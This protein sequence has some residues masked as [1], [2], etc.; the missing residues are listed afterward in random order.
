MLSV[1]RRRKNM[2]IGTLTYTLRNCCV[3]YLR[4]KEY[5]IM[6]KVLRICKI[7]TLRDYLLFNASECVL[8]VKPQTDPDGNTR[9]EAREQSIKT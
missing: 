2:D 9:A 8:N 5:E 7:T 1:I 6:L 3:I 4:R